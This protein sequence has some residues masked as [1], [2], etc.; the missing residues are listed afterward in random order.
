MP[1]SVRKVIT[2]VSLAVTLLVGVVAAPPGNALADASRP[3]AK[4]SPIST[5]MLKDS[6]FPCDPKG[7]CLGC[8]SYNFKARFDYQRFDG[9]LVDYDENAKARWASNTAGHPGGWAVF[10]LDGN[11]VVYDSGG[12]PL[13]ASHTAGHPNAHGVCQEDGN[14]VIYDGTK[15]LWATHT[16]H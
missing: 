9:N 7:R 12:H 5:Y 6:P 8:A 4:Q 15:A 16:T 1:R 2:G 3:S 14:V 10:Q 11:L 13:W